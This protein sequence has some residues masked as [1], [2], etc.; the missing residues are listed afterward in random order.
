M[1]FLKQCMT[2]LAA[3]T[4][5]FSAAA[6]T[7]DVGGAKIE[8]AIELQGSKLQ[9]NGAGVRYR[10]V[11]KVHAAGLYLSKKWVCLKQSLPLRVSSA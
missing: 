6:A 5:Y 9:L 11:F 2:A 3:L 4:I 10:A 7:I 1:R 8:D